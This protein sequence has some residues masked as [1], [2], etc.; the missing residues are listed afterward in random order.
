MEEEKTEE[1]EIKKEGWFEPEGELVADVWETDEEIVV[2][3]PIA[4]TKS[5]DIEI[6]IEGDILKIKG[7]RTNP[8]NDEKD[9]KYLLRECYFGPFSKE[10]SLP[11]SI[12]KQSVR[13]TIEEGIL[14]VHLPKKEIPGQKIEIEEK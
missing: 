6:I 13:A 11:E 2:Q 4:G 10:I 8:E 3:A 7:K 5:E 1:V 14:T 9:K 12:D